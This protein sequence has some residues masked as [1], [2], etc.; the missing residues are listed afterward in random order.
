MYVYRN[1]S[2][3]FSKE[4]KDIPFQFDFKVQERD[5][6]CGLAQF[7]IQT[8]ML[9]SYY[10]HKVSKD[11]SLIPVL[12]ELFD[13]SKPRVFWKVKFIWPD[14]DLGLYEFLKE[15]ALKVLI[16]TELLCNTGINV[17]QAMLNNIEENKVLDME[18]EAVASL[19]TNAAQRGII[20]LQDY[21]LEAPDSESNWPYIAMFLSPN[22]VPFCFSF[23]KLIKKIE[24]ENE[25]ESEE[26]EVQPN[27]LKRAKR[28]RKQDLSKVP[29]LDKPWDEQASASSASSTM[30]ISMIAW[31][32]VYFRIDY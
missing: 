8:R 13:D 22:L 28:P 15:F 2:M 21:Q 32:E 23:I 24:K 27:S 14:K 17:S 20:I 9:I 3:A 5:G 26:E 16:N 6:F 10:Q 7:K 12:F 1:I 19:A 31:R 4:N 11:Q 18:S 25:S 30:A 29:G